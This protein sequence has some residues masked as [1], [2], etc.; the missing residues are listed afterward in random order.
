MRVIFDQTIFERLDELRARS[1]AKA[2]EFSNA[3]K[4][5]IAQGDNDRPNEAVR[6]LVKEARKLRAD[7]LKQL[8]TLQRTIGISEA[9][10]RAIEH[11][12]EFEL[13][14]RADGRFWRTEIEQVPPNE[15]QDLDELA[16]TG[17][18]RLLA[19]VDPQWLRLEAQKPYRLQS[20][21]LNN[22]LHFVNGVRLG[23]NMD[24][25]SPQRFA[26]MLL[27]TQDH[28]MKE[29]ELD[30]FSAA[31]FV[32]EIAVLGNNLDEIRQLGPEA[33]RKLAAL[34]SMTDDMVSS[35]LYELFVGA[36]CVRKGIKLTMVEKDSS[37]KTP[38]FQIAGLGPIPGAIECKRRLG[39]TMY[40]MDEAQRVEAFYALVRPALHAADIHGVIEVSFTVP[41]RSVPSAQF[42]DEVLVALKY[43]E[44]LI[45]TQWGSLIFRNL[46]HRRTV[47]ETRL[48]S[49]EYL[50]QVFEWNP[51]QDEW[52]GLLCEV[53]PPGQIAVELFTMPRCLKWRSVSEEAVTKK[54]RGITSLWGDAVKQ[55]PA[56]EIGFVYIAYHEGSRPAVAD[57]RTH[58][59]LEAGA[60]LWYRWSIRVPLMF[61]S[62]LYPRSLGPGNPDLIESVLAGAAEGLES[63]LKKLPWRVFT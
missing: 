8:R 31:M 28:L 7:F 33:H 53:E 60:D 35:T 36:A 13:L 39:L 47:T 55:I 62:R 30:F 61:V 32:P 40:E 59:I 24:R 43:E 49:P 17:L 1:E 12:Q 26:K 4:T 38:D 27:V 15:S 3:I 44:T 42:V 54:A 9:E 6:R 34:P 20:A 57:A 22:P 29:W 63:W 10:I 52:D 11:A 46:P 2:T 21:F 25:V 14:P 18:E 37:R 50:Q 41:V 51:L 56:G 16:K 45:T 19:H 58:H 23:V 48:C 5:Q